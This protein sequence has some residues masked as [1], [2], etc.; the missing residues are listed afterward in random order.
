[1]FDEIEMGELC[2]YISCYQ[3]K[4]YHFKL[5]D[6]YFSLYCH[7]QKYIMSATLIIIII[8][9]ISIYIA[10]YDALLNKT[11]AL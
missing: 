2:N 1:M 8:I 9:K 6:V 11:I 4:I 3:V 5:Y 7:F 10:L